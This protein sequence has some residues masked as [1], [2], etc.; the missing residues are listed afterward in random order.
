MN[1]RKKMI[2]K[3]IVAVLLITLAVNFIL[4][5]AYSPLFRVGIFIMSNLVKRTQVR[6][7]CETDHQVLLEACRELSRR[8]NV[9]DLRHGTYYFRGG[10]RRP[11]VSQFPQPILDLAPHVVMIDPDGRV[12][13]G[14][15]GGFVNFGLI[16]YP[17]DYKEPFRNFVYGD[18]KIIDGLWYHDAEYEG[19]PAYQKRIEDLIQKGKQAYGN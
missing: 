11:A 3:I 4:P 14:M 5:A 7:L 19:S 16:A 18:K 15:G 6:L 9:G 8:V 12:V 10:S 13:L 1:S 17:E 2:V